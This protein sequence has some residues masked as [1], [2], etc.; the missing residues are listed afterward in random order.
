MN[1][2]QELLDFIASFNKQAGEYT[3]DELFQIGVAHKSL[4]GGDKNWNELAAILG[5][6]Q[7]GE[8][9]RKAIVRRQARGNFAEEYT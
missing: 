6:T 8:N 2:K 4:P 1:T 7:S 5:T 9:Y 3:A